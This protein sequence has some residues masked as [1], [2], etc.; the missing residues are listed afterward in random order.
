MMW[1]PCGCPT[2]CGRGAFIVGTLRP[3]VAASEGR[4]GAPQ[5]RPL[6]GCR[7]AHPG[8]LDL[9]EGLQHGLQR[10]NDLPCAPHGGAAPSPTLPPCPAAQTRLP[11]PAPRERRVDKPWRR[12]SRCAGEVPATTS[13]VRALQSSGRWALYPPLLRGVP[14]ERVGRRKSRGHW[15]SGAATCVASPRPGAASQAS[16]GTRVCKRHPAPWRHLEWRGGEAASLSVI[17]Q[18]AV[19]GRRDPLTFTQQ[20]Q[21]AS[22]QSRQGIFQQSRPPIG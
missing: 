8:P 22:R 7:W 21:A 3:L 4:L 16:S 18:P 9:V 1:T 2:A 13:A 5:A 10:G 20:L 14:G 15:P 19:D 17:S 12:L 11:A 6:G